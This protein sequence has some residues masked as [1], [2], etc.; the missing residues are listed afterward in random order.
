MLAGGEQF[1]GAQRAAG[2]H[3]PGGGIG[4]AVAVTPAAG[5]FG[6]DAV[7]VAAVGAAQ[8]SDVDDLMFGQDLHTVAFGEP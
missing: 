6:G 4:A 3:H 5:M 8:R 1:V 7:A 2:E